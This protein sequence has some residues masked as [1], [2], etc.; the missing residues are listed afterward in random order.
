MFVGSGFVTSS[1]LFLIK[2]GGSK[3]FD[4]AVSYCDGFGM[5]LPVPTGGSY[6]WS[7]TQLK[8]GEIWLGLSDEK[9]EGNWTN[10]YTGEPLHYKLLQQIEKNDSNY[11]FDGEPDN[12]GGVEHHAILN[13]DQKGKWN[14]VN[15]NE[16]KNTICVLKSKYMSQIKIQK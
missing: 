2:R 5:H 9:S 15:K 16:S 12:R 7:L 1:Q 11:W 3:S 10:I 13:T 6:V 4:E 14:D 8:H